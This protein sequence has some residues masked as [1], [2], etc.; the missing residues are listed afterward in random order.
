MLPPQAEHL[1]C[2]RAMRTVSRKASGASRNAR[3]KQHGG[4]RWQDILTSA[5]GQ[6][7]SA[8][9]QRAVAA[10]SSL[11]AAVLDLESK[12]SY[13]SSEQFVPQ[14]KDGESPKSKKK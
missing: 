10:G 13:G 1:R 12:K 11:V 5:S 9:P 3:Q 8:M 4:A 7:T 2:W 14:L 6:A